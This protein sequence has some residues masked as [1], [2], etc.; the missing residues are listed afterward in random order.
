MSSSVN[1]VPSIVE[2]LTSLIGINSISSVLP[3]YDQSNLAV[4]DTLAG[5]FESLGF[6]IEVLPIAGAPGKANLLATLGKGDGGLV[7]SGHTD[8]V[9]CNPELW[10]S[11]PFVLTE[12]DNRYYGLGTCDMKGFFSMILE[13]VQ[14]FRAADFK[15]PLMVLATADEESSMVGARALARQGN[16]KGRYAVIGEPTSLRPIRMHKGIIMETVRL[17]GKAGH[18]SNPDLGINSIDAMHDV[19]GE[20]KNIRRDLSAQYHNAHFAVST[21]TL[22]LGCIHGGDNPNRICGSCELAFDLRALPGMSNDDLREEI[23]RRLS[24][25]AAQNQVQFEL[26]TLFPGIEPFST[27]E[28]SPLVQ[29]AE[30]LTGYR[31]EAVAFA[32]E[33]PFLQELGFETI[34]MGPGSIDQAHQVDEFLAFDQID[35]CVSLLRSLIRQFCVD[36]A[37]A[38]D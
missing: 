22:N 1:K 28:Q 38:R 7:L 5:W 3:Q 32:T 18:S 12:R 29:A 2:S 33:A 24:P 17:T 35:P 8:T 11:D 15:Q 30:R 13:A 26:E 10:R 9:P 6:A 21:P 25:I 16:L 20:L 23:R 19:I 36:A 31:S 4:I 37:D 34:V 27:S 14:V